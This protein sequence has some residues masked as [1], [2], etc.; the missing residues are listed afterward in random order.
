MGFQQIITYKNGDPTI[1]YVL[2]IE[3]FVQLASGGAGRIE[4]E[5]DE[6]DESD[7]FDQSIKRERLLR[8]QSRSFSIKD[9]MTKQE[10]YDRW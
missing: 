10:L 9:A 2:D 1:P 7:E 4:V 5:S 6:S 3:E 8:S